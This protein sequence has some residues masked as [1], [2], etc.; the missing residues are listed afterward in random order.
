MQHDL[1][2]EHYVSEYEDPGSYIKEITYS[3]SLQ[4]II[5]LIDNSINCKQHIEIKC[6]NAG[7]SYP[8][9]NH[10]WWQNRGGGIMYNWGAPTGTVGC[11]CSTWNGTVCRAPLDIIGHRR[12]GRDIFFS[13][14]P[15]NGN[16]LFFSFLLS[17]VIF[18]P[19]YLMPRWTSNTCDC[20]KRVNDVTKKSK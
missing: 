6:K 16:C 20:L 4:Q 14:G 9:S 1:E 3:A 19:F 2:Q 12:L 5:A 11:D 8:Y 15:V 7:F 13:F 18:Q 10:H 17:K